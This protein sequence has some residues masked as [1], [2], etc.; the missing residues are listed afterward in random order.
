[1]MSQSVG[2]QTET[3]KAKPFLDRFAEGI[4]GDIRRQ[5]QVEPFEKA[6]GMPS[7]DLSSEDRRFNYT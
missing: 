2:L 1:M 7:F 6:Q 3:P 4:I 5:R